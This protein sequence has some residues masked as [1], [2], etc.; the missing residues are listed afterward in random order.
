MRLLRCETAHI[1][2]PNVQYC[3]GVSSDFSWDDLRVFLAVHRHRSHGA[4]ARLLGIHVSTIGR[5]VAALE[6]ALGARLFARTPAGLELTAAG[7]TLVARAVRVEEEALAAERALGGSDARASGTVRVTASDGMVHYLLM[8]AL[9]NLRRSHPGVVLDLRADAHPLELLRREAD[10]AVRLFR[11]KG[12]SLI[13]RRCATMRNGLY[14]SQAYLARRATPRSA[15]ELR[16][17]DFIGFDASFDGVPTLRWLRRHVPEPRWTVRASTSTPQV[18]ACV[19][20]AGIAIV[21]SFIA[22][23]EPRLVPVLPALQPPSRDVWLVVHEDLRKQARIAAVLDWLRM[24][25]KHLDA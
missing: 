1:C 23:R 18:L 2:K 12:A 13:A 3:N 22:R 11:P 21:A 10:I 7:T 4:A 25:V 15:T 5:R 16:D 14:A 17:H 6:S 9:D 20:G 24:T 19:E 8:P